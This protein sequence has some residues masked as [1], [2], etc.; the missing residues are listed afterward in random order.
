MKLIKSIKI[1]LIYYI[2]ITLKRSNKNKLI[3]FKIKVNKI[4]KL[5]INK[6][7]KVKKHKSNILMQIK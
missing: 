4:K 2:S 7:I 1:N 6:M 3:N 5:K